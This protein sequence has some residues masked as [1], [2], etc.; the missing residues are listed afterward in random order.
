MLL[1]FGGLDSREQLNVLSSVGNEYELT[2]ISHALRIQFPTCS[3]ASKGLF[4]VLKGFGVTT[5]ASLDKRP[6]GQQGKRTQK[7]C[8]CGFFGGVLPEVSSGM[9]T[10]RFEMD[11]AEPEVYMVLKNN[12]LC[13]HSEYQGGN[14]RHLVVNDKATL[15]DFEKE[16]EVL[17]TTTVDSP[18]VAHGTLTWGGS[19]RASEI[20]AANL[21]YNDVLGPGQ[22][23]DD[24]DLHQDNFDLWR[25]D[26]QA[27]DVEAAQQQDSRDGDVSEDVNYFEEHVAQDP[28]FFS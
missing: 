23:P 11:A 18:T 6:K 13:E 3:G 10:N 27:W 28:I 12:D 21:A 17:Q 14:E 24:R 19:P 16:D 22:C 9:F 8:L 5:A 1:A 4:G 25:Q 7:L 2:K 15:S 26:A 20:D